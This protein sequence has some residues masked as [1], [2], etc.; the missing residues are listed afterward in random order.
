MITW[1]WPTLPLTLGVSHL[2]APRVLQGGIKKPFLKIV[3]AAPFLVTPC[4]G[5]GVPAIDAALFAPP[6]TARMQI[7]LC[8]SVCPVTLCRERPSTL[9]QLFAQ[10]CMCSFPVVCI[11]PFAFSGFVQPTREF[12][13]SCMAANSATYA[14]KEAGTYPLKNKCAHTRLASQAC[15]KWAST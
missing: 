3:M 8:I 11:S 2:F 13:S 5:I 9:A 4:K 12:W 1:S 10:N 6:F 7:G 15:L 14:L